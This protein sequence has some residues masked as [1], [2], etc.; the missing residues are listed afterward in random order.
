V[1]VFMENPNGDGWAHLLSDLN[2]EEGR[3]ELVSFGRK[4]GLRRRIHRKGSYAEHFDIRNPEI[5][6]AKAAGARI[7]TRR[8]LGN[9]LREKKRESI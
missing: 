7:I 4:I 8:G 9:I 2:G 5:E 3:E 1:A 6:L